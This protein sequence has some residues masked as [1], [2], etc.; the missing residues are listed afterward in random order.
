MP[1]TV[2]ALDKEGRLVPTADLP[3]E[4]E[5]A[6]AASIIGVGNGD[7][8]DHDP[9]KGNKRRLFN[10]FAQVII[11][12]QRGGSSKLTLTAAAKGLSSGSTMIDVQAAPSAPAL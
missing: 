10:G 4:F 9:E 2:E 12:S 7:P 5:I 6:G 3:V 1:V 11:Q 8:N